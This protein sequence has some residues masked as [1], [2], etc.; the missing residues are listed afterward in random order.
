MIS[1][2]EDLLFLRFLDQILDRHVL[3]LQ[4]PETADRPLQLH[5]RPVAGSGQRRLVVEG[6]RAD[7]D[8]MFGERRPPAENA[9]LLIG[10]SVIQAKGHLAEVRQPAV[11]RLEQAMGGCGDDVLPDAERR[12]QRLCGLL[13][14]HPDLAFEGAQFLRQIAPVVIAEDGNGD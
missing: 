9:G 13:V 8:V 3:D 2:L 1:H 4:R 10:F 5:Q 7:R 6:R 12:A 14:E 11:L